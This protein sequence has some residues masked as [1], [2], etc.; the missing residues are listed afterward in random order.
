[1]KA[2]WVA[3]L[4]M[5][6]L[7]SD[8]LTKVML[9]DMLEPGQSLPVVPGYF[10]LVH[11]RNPGAAF[12]L[13]AQGS[14]PWRAAFLIGVAVAAVAGLAWLVR[15]TPVTKRWERGAAAAVIGGALGNLYDRFVY[16]EVIDFLDV[17]LGQWHWPA[18]NVADS[19]ITV[20]AC[21]LVAASL[22]GGRSS[23]QSL[24]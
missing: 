15:H 19:A 13:L 6:V 24:D 10:S 4:A 8:R 16:G 14:V 1:M 2:W 17:Y 20:G 21:V 5:F 7:V 23:P 11:V 9:I 18:F 22:F 3:L 12:G